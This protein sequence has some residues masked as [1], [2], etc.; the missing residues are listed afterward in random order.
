MAYQ[1]LLQGESSLKAQLY[2]I[3]VESKEAPEFIDITNEIA[4]LV[5]DSEII[6]GM[7]VVYSRHTTAAIMINENEPLL[8]EDMARFLEKIASRN[9]HYRHNDF[10]VRMVNMNDGESPNGHAHCQHLILG[11]SQT[12]PIANGQIQMGRWQ[13]VFLVELDR[14]RRREVLIQVLGI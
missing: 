8:L 2:Q 10:S 1:K 14:P 12:I 7:V 6:N 13:S 9:G 3:E 4:G 5:R 11:A